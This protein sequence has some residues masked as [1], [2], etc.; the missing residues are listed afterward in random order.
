MSGLVLDN[1]GDGGA[2]RAHDD[3]VV[4]AEADVLGVVESRDAHVTR[5]P[6]QE[7]AEGLCTRGLI[8]TYA[9]GTLINTCVG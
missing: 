3:D 6:R 4:D 5:L 9:Q 7:A 2:A 1:K 8:N